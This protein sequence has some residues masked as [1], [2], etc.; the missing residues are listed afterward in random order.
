MT[1]GAG[2]P[3]AVTG[4]RVGTTATTGAGVEPAPGATGMSVGRTATTG[5]GVLALATGAG[6]GA[7]TGA[8]V[9]LLVGGVTKL[10]RHVS[11][12]KGTQ[13]NPTPDS[14]LARVGNRAAKLH[15]NVLPR[16]AVP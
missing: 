6:A 13:L 7:G 10:A 2:V 16:F 9:V 8:G 14:R 1:T 15:P 5:A 12:V 4:M 3:P 11:L